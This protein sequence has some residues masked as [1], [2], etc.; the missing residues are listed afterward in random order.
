MYMIWQVIVGNGQQRPLASATVLVLY[1][2]A[3][4]ATA[5][6]TRAVAASVRPAA[7]STIHSVHFY[8]CRTEC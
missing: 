8:T 7:A 3:I 6:T 2:E 5:P 1:V 4:A